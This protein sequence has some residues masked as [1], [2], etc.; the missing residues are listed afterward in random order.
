M[1]TS[2][3][4]MTL[5]LCLMVIF[6][7]LLLAVNPLWKKQ[8]V[9]IAGLDNVCQYRIPALITTNRGTLLAVCDAR[10]EKPGD[11]PNNID[12]VIK[13]SIDNGRTWSM[14][15]TVVDFPEVQAACDPSLLVDRQTGTIWLFYDYSFL[16]R[17]KEDKLICRLHAITSNDDGMSWS[18]PLDLTDSLKDCL[19]H[20]SG[21]ASEVDQKLL[22]VL[23]AGDE[24]QFRIQ[25]A[26][27]MGIQT[28][29]GELVVPVYTY[30]AGIPYPQLMHSNDHGRTWTLS[31]A[32]GSNMNES[33][34][35]ELSNGD[36]MLNCRNLQGHGY[37][38]VAETADFGETW[39]EIRMDKTLIDPECQASII[40]FTDQD[41]G[42]KKSRLLFVNPA[43]SGRHH[44]TNLTV[45]LSYDEGKSWPVSKEI[46]AGPS[47][48]SCLTILPDM[49]IGL[50]YESGQRN[51]YERIAYTRF[52]LEWLTDSKDS[53]PP[54]H[55]YPLRV[56]AFGDSTT[57][58]REG[59][60]QVYS[61]RLAETLLA[62]GIQVKM[63]NAGVPG[64]NTEQARQRFVDDVLAHNPN[65]VIIQFG[66]N[67]AAVDVWKAPPADQPRVPLER[68]AMNLRY[69]V[70]TLKARNAEVV[71]MTPNPLRWTE[72]MRKMYGKAPYDPDDA[73]GF[74]TLLVKYTEIVRQTA[75]EFKIPLVDVFRAYK[76][77]PQQEGQELADLYLDSQ[78]PNDVGHR[79]VA[80][81]LLDVIKEIYDMSL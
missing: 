32:L 37:R 59:V 49:T 47:A 62:R 29:T 36:L 79:L 56:V 6:S 20:R 28:R 50:L 54:H 8:D 69:F 5:A 74:N 44:R 3:Y 80:G 75:D 67:D 55:V 34:V 42:Y 70:T 33:Q 43:Q 13:R 57:A 22:E 35:V 17:I 1:L 72:E 73:D 61:E 48:Y 64:Q 60:K 38:S 16:S 68:Y 78:H 12:L 40:R 23:S 15:Q 63:V 24:T 4:R 71:L 30:C 76:A 39:S 27:G 58:Y 41:A 2:T 19:R 81:L 7:D 51:P 10:V 25:V 52:N 46:H 31:T 45:R 66:I 26:P 21:Q 9:Y 53:L 77:Y 18:E 14:M 65:L 11:S